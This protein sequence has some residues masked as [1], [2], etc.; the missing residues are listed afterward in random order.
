MAGPVAAVLASVLVLAACTEP[1]PPGGPASGA[2]STSVP[3]TDSTD[4]TGTADLGIS[5]NPTAEPLS[6]GSG[7]SRVRR[8]VQRKPPERCRPAVDVDRRSLDGR[9]DWA[10][11]CPGASG[12][13]APAHVPVAP[14][15][16]R[17]RLLEAIT[18]GRQPIGGAAVSDEGI[19]YGCRPGSGRT[20]RLQIGYA[21]GRV[22]ELRGHTD[23][24]CTARF[25]GAAARAADS[26]VRGPAGLGVF[27]IA[28][29]AHGRQTADRLEAA[30]EPVGDLPALSCP[31]SPRFL[32][33]VVEDGA[34]VG[35]VEGGRTER[36]GAPRMPASAVRGIA[37]SWAFRQQ[38]G[39]PAVRDLTARE[40]E[41]VRIGLHA[42]DPSLADCVIRPEPTT[43]AV[44]EDAFG[45]RRAIAIDDSCAGGVSGSTYGT[46]FAW[47]DR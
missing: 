8:V 39:A 36:S 38:T 37:C 9:I 7:R 5:A 20:F 22:A 45:T 25:A 24:G 42:V 29:L 10:R 19:P 1:S 4:P 23:P 30:E 11:F 21:D 43:V 17:L 46:G 33:S 16:S 40:A 15:V 31:P 26:Q 12:R 35:R 6:T 3:P 41:R 27:G 44:V 14:L 28:M 32:E 18:P 2:A 34:S 47:L 13:T